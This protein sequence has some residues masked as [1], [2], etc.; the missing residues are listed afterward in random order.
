MNSRERLIRISRGDAGG[1]SKNSSRRL[2]ACE[3]ALS[4]LK[5]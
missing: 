1:L 4:E 3:A 5:S 2:A